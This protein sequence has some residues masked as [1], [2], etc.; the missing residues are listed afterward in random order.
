MSPASRQRAN[1]RREPTAARTAA[2]GTAGM[3]SQIALMI[4]V[5]NTAY[6]NSGITPRLNLVHARGLH[7]LRLLKQPKKETTQS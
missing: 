6:A 4:Q 7:K 3:N 5:A 1:E 2:G